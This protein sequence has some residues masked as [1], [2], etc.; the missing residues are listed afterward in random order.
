METNDADSLSV[1]FNSS[2]ALGKS[3]SSKK[4]EIF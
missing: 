4:G 1:T 3:P 2:V